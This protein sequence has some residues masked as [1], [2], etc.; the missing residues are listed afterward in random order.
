MLTPQSPNKENQSPS[1]Q[2]G[3]KQADR[4]LSPSPHTSKRLRARLADYQFE[5]KKLE[6][7]FA[8][9]R[10]LSGLEKEKAV[11]RLREELEGERAK[12]AEESRRWERKFAERQELWD[13]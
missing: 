5:I 7:D 11:R 6:E 8:E 1:P 9:F 10:L 3:Y 4:T 13:A 12:N 2:R